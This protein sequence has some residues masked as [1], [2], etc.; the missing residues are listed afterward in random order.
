MP[1]IVMNFRSTGEPGSH[2]RHF[3]YDCVVQEGGSLATTVPQG[4]ADSE[5]LAGRAR[6]ADEQPEPIA[7]ADAP[8][9][10]APLADALDA[11]SVKDLRAYA[12]ERGITIGAAATTKDAIQAVIRAVAGESSP[13][14]SA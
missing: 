13:P 10:S 3:G 8:L 4:L 7:P 5:I 1:T 2:E 11:M 14:A 9:P 12:K 6:L